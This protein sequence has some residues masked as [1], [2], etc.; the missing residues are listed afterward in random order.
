MF[1]IQGLE[2]PEMLGDLTKDRAVHFPGLVTTGKHRDRDQPTK[3]KQRDKIQSV[4]RV[5]GMHGGREKV[6][7][8][9]VDVLPGTYPLRS[10][11]VCRLVA[12]HTLGSVPSRSNDRRLHC[13]WYRPL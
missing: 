8:G 2:C 5:D 1:E 13:V 6:E 12:R 3:K 4:N 9:E 11:N 7:G 10:W